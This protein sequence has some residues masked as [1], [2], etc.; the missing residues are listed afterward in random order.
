RMR[1]S[2]SLFAPVGQELKRGRLGPHYPRLRRSYRML[3]G[4]A[5]VGCSCIAVYVGSL[6]RAD[7]AAATDEAEALR[8]LERDFS[9]GRDRSL[10]AGPFKT[11][12]H[13]R[14]SNAVDEDIKIR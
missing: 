12:L 1:L 10:D 11:P 13:F 8:R 14:L 4:V 7:V 6:L 5:F 2:L 9:R 3:A